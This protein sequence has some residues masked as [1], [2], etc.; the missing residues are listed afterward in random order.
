MCISSLKF[1]SVIFVVIWFLPPTTT[2]FTLN[3]SDS[4]GFFIFAKNS[5]K[6][7]LLKF[8]MVSDSYIVI[9]APAI[10]KFLLLLA[11]L[12]RFVELDTVSS[13]Y[14][15]VYSSPRFL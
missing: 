8:G 13:I 5:E 4:V 6:A 12:Y 1:A 11:N 3:L 15:I 10:I 7:V 2:K 9:F 14:M